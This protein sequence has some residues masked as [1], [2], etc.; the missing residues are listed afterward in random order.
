VTEL[1]P[2]ISLQDASLESIFKDTDDNKHYRRV[3]GNVKS[4]ALTIAN[5]VDQEQVTD[6]AK[7]FPTS[8]MLAKLALEGINLSQITF[9]SITNHGINDIYQS[10]YSGFRAG[11]QAGTVDG[12]TP[13]GSGETQNFAVGSSTK[14]YLKC[15]TGV[16]SFVYV[17]YWI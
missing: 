11:F 2:T 17:T 15:E 10:S 5:P 9:V 12:G 7:E 8:S 14:F 16:T 13:I 3:R 6:I 1:R 4:P